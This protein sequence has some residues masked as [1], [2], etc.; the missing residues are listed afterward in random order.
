LH[1]GAQ[2]ARELNRLDIHNCS[3]LTQSAER[4]VLELL[5]SAWVEVD[6]LV[7]LDQ[8][9]L[10]DCGVVTARV[11]Q[12]LAELAR[13]RGDFPVLADSRERIGLFRGVSLKPNQR[14]AQRASGESDLAM[15]ARVLARQT[16]APVL[17]T[18]GQEGIVLTWPDGGLVRVPGYPVSGPIDPVGAGDSTSAGIISALA[19]GASLPEAAALGNL[20][21]S[22]TVQQLGTTGTA[23][24][25]QVRQRW[26]E[27]SAEGAHG[28]HVRTTSTRSATR[29]GSSSSNV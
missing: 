4:R 28:A 29:P 17:C 22:I 14:E 8:V 18:C 23:T 1:Q 9:S 11:R 7:V 16:G 3:P 5:E 13:A 26:G 10:P 20:V 19:S 24:P 25:E 15:A 2:P 6:A 12:R 21:A 27:V